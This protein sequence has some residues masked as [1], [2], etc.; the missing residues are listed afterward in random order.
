[1][2]QSGVMEDINS[3]KCYLST[4]TISKALKCLKQPFMTLDQLWATLF[5]KTHDK[6]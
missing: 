2:F 4:D 5:P 6:T 1:M 3:I